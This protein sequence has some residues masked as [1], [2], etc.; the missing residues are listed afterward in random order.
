MMKN[1]MFPPKRDLVSGAKNCALR[2]EA[3][4]NML[5]A[6]DC[7][8]DPDLWER[9]LDGAIGW[10]EQHLMCVETLAQLEA[11]EEH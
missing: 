7:D 3:F 9:T 8:N 11:S 1:T 10:G 6:V 2:A 4:F 5:N